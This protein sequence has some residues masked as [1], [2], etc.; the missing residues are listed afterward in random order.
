MTKSPRHLPKRLLT[1]LVMAG[2]AFAAG[3]QDKPDDIRLPD[4][5]SSA[6]ALVSP[7]EL[8]DYGQMML[9]QMR[10]LDMVVDDPL[11]DDYI[12]NLGFRLV[13]NS[14]KP[15]D[16]FAFFIAKDPVINAF[17]APGGYIGIN[18]GLIIIT[19]NHDELAAVMAHEI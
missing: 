12:N 11:A 6:N 5:G 3:A 16:H 17:S 7:Q 9:E 15:K 4:L 1:T 18:S 10:A 19:G 8:Q 13:A 2:L 14:A